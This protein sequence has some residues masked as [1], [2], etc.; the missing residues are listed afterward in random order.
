MNPGKGPGGCGFLNEHKGEMCAREP[1]K[2]ATMERRGAAEQ[3]SGIGG[4]MVR[5]KETN[6][7]DPDEQ[8]ATQ[9]TFVE[10]MSPIDTTAEEEVIQGLH[11]IVSA[12]LENALMGNINC[13]RV[14]MGRSEKVRA[15]E[16]E[17]PCIS[18]A[19]SWSAE[20]EWVGESSEAGAETAAGSRE[21]EE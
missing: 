15:S 10:G 3:K 4:E 13:A 17:L 9:G 7:A 11:Q 2:S 12:M 19:D 5:T 20:P 18:L 1:A 6:A 8:K 14:L 21:P 16:K